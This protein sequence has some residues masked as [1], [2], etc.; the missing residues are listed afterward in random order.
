MTVP[1]KRTV[2]LVILAFAC[3]AAAVGATVADSGGGERNPGTK[4]PPHVSR[5]AKPA[6]GY[7]T[8]RR[9]RDAKPYPMPY[10]PAQGAPR[11]TGTGGSTGEPG[12]VS[13]SPAPQR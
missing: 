13:G 1:R 11:D 6:P 5:P 10:A 8:K 7:W 12:T 9:M 2:S 4:R 3:S